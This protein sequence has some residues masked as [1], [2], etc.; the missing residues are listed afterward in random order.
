[1]VDNGTNACAAIAA[2]REL[3]CDVIVT[4]HHGTSEGVAE[5]LA[6]LNP[7]LPEAGYPDRDLAGVGVAFKL[8]TAVARSFSAGRQVSEEFRAFLVEAL[9]YVALGTIAD[10]APLR[11]ENRVMV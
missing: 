7:R 10:V 6:I 1:S 4:D 3:G 8:A 5:A 11:G 9:A 2:M